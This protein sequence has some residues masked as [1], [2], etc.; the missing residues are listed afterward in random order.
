MLNIGLTMTRLSSWDFNIAFI[1]LLPLVSTV[2]DTMQEGANTT[3]IDVSVDLIS[4]KSCK[5]KQQFNN[6]ML[7]QRRA[8]M[9]GM[10]SDSSLSVSV[11]VLSTAKI[12]QR[13]MSLQLSWSSNN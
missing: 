4:K 12:G 10:Y 11:L 13:V 8:S 1:V 7:M 5:P 9:H 3:W 2:A 6:K